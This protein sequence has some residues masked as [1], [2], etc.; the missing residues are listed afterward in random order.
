MD[1]NIK[2]IVR[3]YVQSIE[4]D[5]TT[6]F[7]KTDTMDSVGSGFFIDST[8]IITCYHVVEDSI[9]N[10]IT[11]PSLGKKKYNV[12]FVSCCPMLDIALLRTTDYE[13]ADFLEMDDSDQVKMTEEVY[14][15]GYPLGQINVK[16]SSGIIS[17][18]QD[19]LFQIDA[20]INNGNS[21][22]PLINKNNK[23]KS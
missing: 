13:S 16:Y 5:W 2:S 11:I 10:L 1:I 14:A 3:I 6:P 20:A 22:G 23:A 9:T 21:G 7:N 4:Y 18:I 15:V 17:G 12:E 8:H 19:Y